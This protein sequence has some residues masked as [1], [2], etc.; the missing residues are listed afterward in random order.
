MIRMWKEKRGNLNKGHRVW[1]FGELT[2]R[3][4]EASSGCWNWLWCVWLLK[5]VRQSE[6]AV[7]HSS[8]PDEQSVPLRLRGDWLSS[9]LTLLLHRLLLP[10]YLLA[11]SFFPLH[12]PPLFS[13]L[14]ILLLL[15]QSFLLSPSPLSPYPRFYLPCHSLCSVLS[16]WVSTLSLIIKE[17]AL[18]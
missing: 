7:W 5:K 15:L 12:S 9:G 6:R 2:A 14:L 13:I 10:A 11:T 18:L 3:S 17:Y 8:T 4:T 16:R 1:S